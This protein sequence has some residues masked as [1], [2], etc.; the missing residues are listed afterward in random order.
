MNSTELNRLEHDPQIIK[1]YVKK[2]AFGKNKMMYL[3][4]IVGIMICV[5]LAFVVYEGM[6]Q[7][8]GYTLVSILVVVAIICFIGVA[9]LNRAAHKKLSQE[10][11]LVPICIAQKYTG[12]MPVIITMLFIPVVPGGMMRHL[13]SI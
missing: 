3:P 2:S 12:R 11:S 5:F 1:D 7:D 10:T 4:L 9:V 13:L 8:V 6:I